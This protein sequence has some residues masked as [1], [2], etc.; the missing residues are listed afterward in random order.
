MGDANCIYHFDLYRLES[1][2]ELS[3]IGVRDYFAEDALILLEW[4]EKAEALLPP[5]DLL[6]RIHIAASGRQLE[7]L[8]QTLSGEKFLKQLQ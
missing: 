8:G 3:S 1:P 4:P 5:A 6:V 7:L 2:E